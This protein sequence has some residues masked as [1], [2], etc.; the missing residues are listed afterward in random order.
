VID[1]LDYIF[2]D[3]DGPIL[4][5]KKRHYECYY[6]II[7]FYGGDPIDIDEYWKLKRSKTKRTELLKLSNFKGEYE[8]FIQSWLSNIEEKC[9]LKYDELKP[10][11]HNTLSKLRKLTK[12]LYLVTMRNNKKNLFEQLK[13][14]NI[15]KYFDNVIVCGTTIEH[16]KFIAL[17]NLDCNSKHS[18]FIGDTEEDTETAKKLGIVSIGI[19]NGLRDKNNL[20]ADYYVNEL[21]EIELEI[22]FNNKL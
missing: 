6:D 5:G 22:I 1:L 7:K 2:L 12:N 8:D 14:L 20:H 11:T 9:Y 4:D 21:S 13:D 19:L 15:N 10:D 18:I 17:R 3:L 16:S